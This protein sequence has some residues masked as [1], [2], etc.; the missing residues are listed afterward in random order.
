MGSVEPNCQLSH[1]YVAQGDAELLINL[2]K[3]NNNFT[4]LTSCCLLAHQKLV[5][6]EKLF[7]EVDSMVIVANNAVLGVFHYWQ[8]L[9]C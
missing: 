3:F 8:L 7:C 2:N 9:L 4:I 1:P 6:I 5:D